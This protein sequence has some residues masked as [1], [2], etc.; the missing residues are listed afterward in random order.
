MRDFKALV[1]THIA[2]LALSDARARK[3]IDEWAAQLEDVYD[4][5]RGDGWSDEDAW[6]QL[7]HHLPDDGLLGRELLDAEPILMRLSSPSHGP[8]A[9]PA[10][11]AFAATLKEAFT[12]G[13]GRDVAQSLKLLVKQRSFNAAIVATLA[14][15]LG[16]NVAIFT[17]VHAVLLRPIPVPDADRIV[18]IGD[19]YPTVTPNDILASD[20]P[21]YFDR[22]K[23]VTTLEEQALF[24]FWY[25]TF[26]I[27]GV[28]LEIRGVRTTPSLFRLLQVSPALGRVF[29]EEE[30]EVGAENTIV[31][32]HGLWQ[33]L[34]GG[35]PAVIGRTLRLGWTGQPYTI[36]GIMPP[37][38]SFFDQGSDGHSDGAN[39]GVQFWLP[40]ALT[41]AQKAD[42]ARARYGFFHI[43]RMRQDATIDQVQAQ[44]DA[45]HA[46]YVRRFPQ[47]RFA[48]LG[49][50]TVVTPLQ[51]ALTRTVGQTLYLL[52][53][54]AGVVLLIGALNIAHLALTRASTRSR[55]LATRVALGASRVQVLR[56]LVLEAMAPCAIGGLAAVAVGGALL[57][58]LRLRGLET[59]PNAARIELDPPVIAMVIGVSIAA[60]VMIGLVS[61]ATARA[62]SVR[63]LAEGDRTGTGSPLARLFR[64]GLVVT[65]VA[66]AV[67]LMVAATLLFLSLRH[68]L[69]VETGITA[70]RVTTATIF[71]PPSRYP[72]AAS[73]TAFTDR[74]LERVRTI[75]GVEA[76]GLTSNVA[77]SGFASPA[78]VSLS[79]S[80]DGEPQVVPSIVGVSPG[81]FEAMST[82]LLRGRYFTGRDRGNTLRVAIV[83]E[84]LAARLWPAGDPIG[85]RIYRG[86]SEPYTVV[87]IVRDVRFESPAAPGDS[88]GTAYFPLTQAPPLRRLRWIAVK[89]L[90]EAGAVVRSLRAAL[91]EVDPNLPLA[92]IQTM[93]ERTL[94]SVVPQRLA[95]ALAMMFALVA[96]FLSLLGMYSVLANVVARRSREFGIRMALGS[97]VRSVF[98]LVLGEGVTLIAAGLLL[99]LAGAYAAGRVLEGQVFG[100]RPTDPLILA[101]VVVVAGTVALLACLA[102][103]RRATRVDPVSVL[104]Q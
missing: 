68:L 39:G 43:G 57:R 60:G 45:L 61:A 5:L 93:E 7:E 33:R 15:C 6:S 86:S 1:A 37:E 17:V 29:T 103:A 59:L 11:R 25:D 27:E 51:E 26:I 53:A 52:W 100:V 44:I 87:G 78:S 66:L 41:P 84:R 82:P 24:T 73:L 47:L 8:L 65:Q 98:R 56:Q 71:P 95:M 75:P 54:G 49:M 34:Y 23:A 77:L 48:E 30:G 90:T 92:D 13:I 19:V 10:S 80:A 4:G 38:F 83:D 72:D 16:A 94:R 74:L 102:P 9:T 55:E 64:R 28:P 67:V 85:Q 81:Y 76:A 101:A 50:Y 91:L 104:S 40:L 32:S 3:I 31:L 22:R 12:A 21:S 35:D 63:S 14:I 42:S 89:G 96:L 79:E 97:S 62:V 36:L 46:D 88:I 70:A 18:G 69:R 2:P 58:A 20:V 99:G